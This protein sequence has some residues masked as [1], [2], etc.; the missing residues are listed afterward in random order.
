MRRTARYRIESRFVSLLASQQM[1]CFKFHLAQKQQDES[2]L[3]VHHRALEYEVTEDQLALAAMH[4][5][6]AHYQEAA[7]IYKNIFKNNRKYVA[8]NVYI[9][10]CYY[11][12]DYYD[13]SEEVLSSYLQQF[14]HRY[15]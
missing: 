13:V 7:D 1:T 2:Q 12:L 5:L 3:M 6:R 8:L 10:L 11:K 4:Y 15:Y 9:A 14:P